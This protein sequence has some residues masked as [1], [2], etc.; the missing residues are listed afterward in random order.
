MTAAKFERRPLRLGLSSFVFACVFWDCICSP[1]RDRQQG[2][3]GL[4]HQQR[5]LPEDTLRLGANEGEQNYIHISKFTLQ[6]NEIQALPIRAI[7]ITPL[8]VGI[9]NDL[10]LHPVQ[11]QDMSSGTQI[12]HYDFDSFCSFRDI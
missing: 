2:L 4:G 8:I 6:Y 7:Q 1:R 11:M 12:V 3:G 5:R 9:I 10:E